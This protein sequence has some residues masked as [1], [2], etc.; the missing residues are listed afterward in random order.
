MSHSK[1]V[2]Q[3]PS[4]SRLHERLREKSQDVRVRAVTYVAFGDSIT[5]GAMEHGIHEHVQLYHQILRCK[6]VERYPTTLI[7]VI[8]S[9]V[10][11]DTASTALDRFERDVVLYRPDFLTIMFG[12]NDAHGGPQ[13]L[14]LFSEAMLRMI[15]SVKCETEAEILIITP[16]MLA[17]HDNPYIQDVHRD[18]VPGF[19]ETELKGYTCLYVEALHHI[20]EEEHVPI[21]DVYE[22]WRQMEQSGIDIHTRLANGLNHPDREFHSQMAAA[23]ATVLFS[24]EPI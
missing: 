14:P 11:G 10:G 22:M 3:L 12:A 6:I 2:S 7:N 1:G 17:K 23:I 9:G 4:F 16:P 8:N 24:P 21:L 18:L 20:A 5:H 19:F 15:R 13:G